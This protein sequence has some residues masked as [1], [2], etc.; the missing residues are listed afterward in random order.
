MTWHTPVTGWLLGYLK[1]QI[2][3]SLGVNGIAQPE[4][5]TKIK[6]YLFNFNLFLSCLTLY[7]VILTAVVKVVGLQNYVKTIW[8]IKYTVQNRYFWCFTEY[9]ADICRYSDT[10]RVSILVI[11]S[12][13]FE[14][15]CLCVVP[16]LRRA[17]LTLTSRKNRLSSSFVRSC[18]YRGRS[19]TEMSSFS[20]H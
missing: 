4:S 18:A 1:T 17:P 20:L 3:F 8:D 16:P 9:I 11:I 6:C 19:K 7:E 10:Q 2:D 14:S 12:T 13:V 15:F 5:Q